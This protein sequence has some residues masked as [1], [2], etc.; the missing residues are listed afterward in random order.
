MIGYYINDIYLLKIKK[1]RYLSTRRCC[2]LRRNISKGERKRE[3]NEKGEEKRIKDI[4][5]C[6]LRCNI[7]KGERKKEIKEKGKEKRIKTFLFLFLIS[8]RSYN[9]IDDADHEFHPRQCRVLQN[10]FFYSFAYFSMTFS[11]FDISFRL[12]RFLV[13]LRN[14][15]V[16]LKNIRN[17]PIYP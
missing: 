8:K 17:Y 10:S 3:I 16:P 13:C 7:S 11:I 12:P 2:N 4:S 9:S 5:R 14:D 1:K 6:S 15:S